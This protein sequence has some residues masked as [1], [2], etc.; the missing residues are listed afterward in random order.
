MLLAS[1]AS[2]SA[3]E[4]PFKA[5]FSEDVNGSIAIAANGLVQCDA[6]NTQCA[7]ALF[8]QGKKLNNNDWNMEYVDVD[9]D[10]ASFS[11]SASV[12]DLPAGARVLFAGLY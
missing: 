6:L 2:A 9:A 5:V 3:A 10:P 11:S 1:A 4:I 12:L 8:R 7:L